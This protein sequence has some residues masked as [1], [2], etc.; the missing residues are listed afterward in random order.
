[1]IVPRLDEGQVEAP[2]KLGRV[3]YGPESD[4]FPELARVLGPARTVGVEE[5]HLSYSR[6]RSLADRGFE[7][8]PAAFAVMELRMQKTDDE[9]RTS[10]RGLRAG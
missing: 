10:T 8:I 6:A 9:N 3:S 4:G 5:D 7:L 1:V 2:G